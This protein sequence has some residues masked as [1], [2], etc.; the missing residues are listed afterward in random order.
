MSKRYRRTEIA[1]NVQPREEGV[2]PRLSPQSPLP[3]RELP[4]LRKRPAVG[5]WVKGL[6]LFITVCSVASA[7]VGVLHYMDL[8]TNQSGPFGSAPTIVT[9]PGKPPPWMPRTAEDQLVDRF[10]RLKNAK[11][12]EAEAMLGPAAV[13]PERPLRKAEAE[14]LQAQVF[15]RDDLHVEEVLR[16]S[17]LAAHQGEQGAATS[18]VLVTKGNVSAPRLSIWKDDKETEAESSQRT[19]S[20][21]DIHVRVENGRIVPRRP[22]LHTD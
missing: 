22:E 13:V 4:D 2:T 9:V 14:A 12:P 11:D 6:A 21:P 19:M 1:K 8:M 18:Y 16:Y 3:E 20:N 5:E 17:D 10:M 15:L 7:L